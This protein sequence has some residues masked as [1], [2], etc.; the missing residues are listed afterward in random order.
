MTT[1]HYIA[2]GT[3]IRGRWQQLMAVLTGRAIVTRK[4]QP[5]GMDTTEYLLSTPAN[6]DALMTAL[7]D[8][9]EGRGV[10]HSHR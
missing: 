5:D 9:N 8:L 2:P 6:H 7:R 1:N 4:G 3:P 10:P